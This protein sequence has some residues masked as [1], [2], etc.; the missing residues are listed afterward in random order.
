[1]KDKGLMCPQL[2]DEYWKTDPA[3]LV[4]MLVHINNLNVILQEK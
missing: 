4:D 2:K 3:F 1:M